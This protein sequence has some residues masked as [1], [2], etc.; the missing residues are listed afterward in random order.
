MNTTPPH[1]TRAAPSP[2][3]RVGLRWLYLL[4]VVLIAAAVVVQVFFAGAAVL[5]D[6]AYW[7]LHRAFGSVIE[8]GIL[9]MLLLGLASG[10]PWRVQALGGLLY[11]LMTLQYV[12]L[13]LMPQLGAPVLRGLHAANALAL[14]SVALALTL[15]VLRHLRSRPIDYIS[16]IREANP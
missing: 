3:W 12:F 16:R 9:A 11:V 15:R 2:A 6:P 13:Y 1:A 8:T 4:A 5:A 14:F 10:L 7:G